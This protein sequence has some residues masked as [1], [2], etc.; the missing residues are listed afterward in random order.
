MCLAV[1]LL[2]ACSGETRQEPAPAPAVEPAPA[3]PKP[4]PTADPRLVNFEDC[5]A[6]L[7]CKANQD[8]DPSS[9]IVTLRD[10]L[11]RVKE[12][13]DQKSKSLEA[14]E[15]VILA[16]GYASVQAFLEEKDFL[17]TANP[18]WFQKLR[19]SLLGIVEAC[20]K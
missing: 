5:Y 11:D 15:R 10:P 6:K 14:Y 13:L 12:L 18:V 16:A 17:A 7:A 8:F 19:D 9:Q 1:A 3:P 20:E 4:A 2:A